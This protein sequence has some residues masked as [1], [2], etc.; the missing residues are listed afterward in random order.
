[1]EAMNGL[2][3]KMEEIKQEMVK[4]AK[5]GLAVEFKKFF[6]SWPEVEA[7]RWAQYTPYFNDGEPCVFGV[8]NATV[9]LVGD[10]DDGEYGDGFNDEYHFH[11][12]KTGE[13]RKGYEEM[14]ALNGA[15][16]ACSEV[17]Q[18]LFGDHCQVTIWRNK[19]EAEVEEYSHD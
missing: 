9:K 14:Q 19:P 13:K 10:E 3:A 2:K 7:I 11:N 6:E 15:I 1:M 17:M 16:H 8:N 18:V 5:E 4:V 12:Y